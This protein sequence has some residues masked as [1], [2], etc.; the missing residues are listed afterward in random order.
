[1]DTVWLEIE[2]ELQEQHFPD[3][4]DSVV[5]FGAGFC[6]QLLL[7]LL[8]QEGLR[9][10]AFCDNDSRKW[11]TE[12][13]GIPCVAPREL[14]RHRDAAVLVTSIQY[15]PEI[16]E[17]VSRMGFPC[18]NADAFV[19][20]RYL[21]RFREVYGLLD[22]ESQRIYA[23][24]LLSR[25]RGS[26][27][28]IR[29]LCSDGQYFALPEFRFC[30][31]NE[32]FVDCG[33]FTGDNVETF[34][35]NILGAFRKVYAFDGNPAAIAAM[36]RRLAHLGEFWLF[37][38]EQIVCE[39]KLVTDRDGLEVPLCISEQNPTGSFIGSG[40]QYQDASV[41]RVETVSLDGYFRERGEDRIT[42]LKADIEGSEWDMLRGA[43]NTIRR[44]RPKI[45]VCIY[46]SIYDFFRIPL[47]LREW[48]PEYRFAV[49][50][51]WNS[52]SETVLYC[53]V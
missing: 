2:R 26:V 21:D 38:Q 28:G 1:M 12:I 3:P 15:Y 9:I 24:V 17:Q 10:L 22:P 39:Q 46:H 35:K 51:H 11:G 32:T 45:A 42:F 7:P 40:G 25:L 52:F 49:R 43:E 13:D 34:L 29:E 50:Q 48:V 18:C 30:G 14:E 16:R 41:Q 6:C 44:C 31:A 20:G 5:L 53:Y 47:L 37:G 4:G 27:A 36:R 8:R 23:G 33:A 19:V